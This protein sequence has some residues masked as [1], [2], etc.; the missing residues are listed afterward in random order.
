M[1]ALTTWTRGCCP[2]QSR[3]L[4][5]RNACPRHTHTPTPWGLEPGTTATRCC[6]PQPPPPCSYW[7]PPAPLSSPRCQ[8][9]RARNLASAPPDPAGPLTQATSR[10]RP[11][12][13]RTAGGWCPH[14]RAPWTL[15]WATACPGHGAHLQPAACGGRVPTGPPQPPYGAHTHSTAA[16][17]G[18]GVIVLAATHPRTLHTC[19]PAGRASGLHPR[20]PRPGGCLDGANHSDPGA[21]PG[22]RA[23]LAPSGARLFL[24]HARGDPLATGKHKNPLHPGGCRTRSPGVGGRRLTF[25]LRIDRKSVV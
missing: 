19:C 6:R 5:P 10:S 3:R 16:R 15:R 11:T 4:Y 25:Y 18:P 20:Y 7:R 2:P 1:V 22:H 24:T 9:S 17:L 21:S 12:P 23:L 8:P 13:A 14:P